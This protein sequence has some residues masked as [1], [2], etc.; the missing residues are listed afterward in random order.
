LTQPVASSGV[1]AHSKRWLTTRPLLQ[2]DDHDD[3]QHDDDNDD[4]KEQNSQQ[5]SLQQSPSKLALAFQSLINTRRTSSRFVPW[6]AT[7][8][9]ISTSSSSQHQQQQQQVWKL[10]LYRAVACAQHAPNHKRTEPFT[11]TQMIAPSASTHRLAEI[12]YHVTLR[13]QRSNT[14]ATTSLGNRKEQDDDAWAEQVAQQKR[15]KFLQ[16][17]AFLVTVVSNNQAA[18]EDSTT[19]TTMVDPYQPLAFV[20][21]SD[22]RQLEDVRVCHVIII[23]FVL[24]V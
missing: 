7:M 1:T 10:A 2:D 22:E 5:K 4:D 13:K 17:P 24:N 16:V 20:P 23:L 9:S 19:T 15:A 18:A 21:P 11:F 14:A 8:P 6:D 3:H 12:V